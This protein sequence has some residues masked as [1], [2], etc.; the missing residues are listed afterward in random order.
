MTEDRHSDDRSDALPRQ[1][2][3]LPLRDVVLMPGA[4]VPLLVG[5]ERSIRSLEIAA[6]HQKLLAV[7]TQRHG[8]VSDPIGE[9]LFDVGTIAR[10][11]Q[12]LRL[13]DG[14]TKILVEGLHRVHVDRLLDVEDHLE[15]RLTPL[16][17]DTAADH[18]ADDTEF[19]ALS[20]QLAESFEEYVHLQPRLPDEVSRTVAQTEDVAR[21]AD[22]AAAYLLIP[23][24][25]KQKLLDEVD[26]EARTRAVI[27]LLRREIEI[28]RVE[29]RLEEE[30]KDQIE[31]GQ[32]EAYLNERMRAIRKELG[33]GEEDDD[34]V[35]EYL[36]KIES[37]DMSDEAREVAH[38][39]I[40]RLAKMAPMSPESTVIRHYLD[41]LVGLPWNARSQQTLDTRR[42]KRQ[43][44]ADHHGLEKVKERI[45]EFLSVIKLSG[46]VQGTILCLAGPPGVGK[47]SLGRSVAEA[48]GR[49]FVRVS[50]GGMRD[51]AE[52]RGHRRTYIGS[53]PGRI[54]DGLRRAGTRNCVFLLDEIDKL[55]S[56]FRGDPSSALLEVLDPEQNKNYSDHFLE[57]PFDLSEVFF[58]C[59]A[60][61]VH[62]IPPALEDRMEILRLP[63]YLE[64]EKVAIAKEFLLPRLRKTHG[65]NRT[66]FEIADP[67]L[68]DVIGLYTR[69][70]GVRALE[71]QLATICRK[72]ARRKAERRPIPRRIQRANL[73]K[74]LG[75]PQYLRRIVDREPEVGVVTG[76]A[77]TSTGGEILEIEVTMLPGQG[78][79]LI[80]GNLRKVMEE[81]ARAALSYARGL[82]PASADVV[83]KHDIHIHVPEGAVPKDG[84]SAGIA[85][86][87]A[88]VSVL[89][90]RKV[91]REVAM[92]GEVTLRGKVFPIGGLPEKA[93]AAQR[94]G[95]TDIVIPDENEKDYR[96]LSEN[97]R[98]G[99]NW[100]LVR[101]MDDVLD[102]ALM[103]AERRGRRPGAKGESSAPEGPPA[104]G[105]P[106]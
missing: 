22:A 13:P 72:L 99:L 86:A 17:A 61:D 63:G 26:I 74:F 69:E 68:Q 55:G 79:L 9:D 7:A 47:T 96:E 84:P 80:T 20:R 4:V 106:H 38:K 8:E 54:L 78:K 24:A 21:R 44:D 2:P 77:W 29:E 3:L 83:K 57:V 15:G 91:R 11:H 93:V 95:C 39:E 88:L 25:E 104:P 23:A 103:P 43:L 60:N 76:L 58:I 33:Y 53:R 10:V 59:T 90:G 92:T 62:A 73:H 105:G 1:L 12:M 48:M 34:E 40:A 46:D 37:A 14:T 45:L 85:M 18:L 67:A 65:L 41:V 19:V 35:E 51:E 42:V 71:R 101:R 89:T 27:G 56:D 87:T 100:H 81:S 82:V 30:V 50:L 97:V 28:L 16:E 5:R 75:P 94:A 64:H 32:K 6:E 52:I 49:D 31:V 98:K 102:L 66:R 36:E 70:A